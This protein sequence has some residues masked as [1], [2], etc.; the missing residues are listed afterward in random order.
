VR[1]NRELPAPQ[2]GVRRRKLL[3]PE[4]LFHGEARGKVGSSVLR[5]S[6]D[7]LLVEREPAGR[8]PG[9]RRRV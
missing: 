4:E 1:A 9:E 7:G 2:L 3:N 8:K 5:M 6:R